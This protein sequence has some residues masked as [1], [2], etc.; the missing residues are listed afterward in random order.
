VGTPLNCEKTEHVYDK[1]DFYPKFA[2]IDGIYYYNWSCAD[3]NME[4]MCPTPWMMPQHY[5]VTDFTDLKLLHSQWSH[6]GR[7]TSDGWDHDED[8]EWFWFY[9]DGY[10]DESYPNTRL[11]MWVSPNISIPR[12]VSKSDL[13]PVRC[14]KL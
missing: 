11:A 2:V 12:Q 8:G 7:L 4:Q 10:N 5:Y 14:F 13:I 1:T 6:S 9:S 3:I